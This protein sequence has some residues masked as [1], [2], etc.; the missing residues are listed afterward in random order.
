MSDRARTATY[1][2]LDVLIDVY[3]TDCLLAYTMQP[4]LI[5][6]KENVFIQPGACLSS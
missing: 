5:P 2:Q 4:Q 6:E 3:D 1:I